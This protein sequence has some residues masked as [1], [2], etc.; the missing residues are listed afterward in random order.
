MTYNKVVIIS[1]GQSGVD[2]A[3]LDF[4]LKF[5][6]A[7]GGWCPKGRLAEDGV[8]DSKYPLRETHTSDY[9][10]RTKLNIDNSSATL[11]L[12]SGNVDKGTQLTIDYCQLLRKPLLLIDLQSEQDLSIVKIRNWM[13]KYNVQIL[14]IAGPRE[15]SSPG[16]F[17]LTTRF[18]EKLI[19]L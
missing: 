8:I 16:I 7:C 1:G 19:E 10:S 17:E 18:L 4:A 5:G 15:S 13:K 2:R 12:T 14:N 3:A 9:E 6:I 11:V